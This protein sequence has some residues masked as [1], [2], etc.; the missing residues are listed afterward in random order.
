MDLKTYAVDATQ[1]IQ[2]NHEKVIL[3]VYA[4]NVEI[5]E[6]KIRIYQQ[7][8]QIR[9]NYSLLPLPFDIYIQ[10]HSDDNLIKPLK[11]IS[12]SLSEEDYLI[13]FSPNKVQFPL[14]VD[15]PCLQKIHQT[16]READEI[17]PFLYQPVPRS[18]RPYLWRDDGSCCYVI[19]NAQTNWNFPRC[20]ESENLKSANLFKGEKGEHQKE[21]APYLVALPPESELTQ[22]LFSP[23]KE[24]KNGYYSLQHWLSNFGFFFRSSAPFDKL[25]D[26]FRHFVYMP[27]YNERLLYFRF[28]DGK[29]ISQYLERLT[30]YP[31]KLNTFFGGDLIQGILVPD[32]DKFIYF[33]PVVDLTEYK[34]AK[35]QFDKFEMDAY[36][37][38]FNQNLFETVTNDII[39]S[40]SDLL[41]HYSKNE[42]AEI[43]LYNHK[44]SEKYRCIQSNTIIFFTLIALSYG[45]TIEQLDPEKVINQLLTVDYLTEKE[46]I[47]YINQR[48]TVLEKTQ[49]ITNLQE[50]TNDEFSRSL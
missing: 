13:V 23:H 9:L 38:N 11:T 34:T 32:N 15:F 42:I 17:T 39:E 49:Q 24:E 27:T 19:I 7:I 28:Y 37:D 50:N 22:A 14:K 3:L 20:F 47:Y 48:I 5:A 26:H 4:P 45:K 41:E 46:K 43:V 35:K 21:S 25:V 30:Y 36:R 33:E 10:R 40:N 18:V 29:V 12:Q 8:H 6:N 44:V 1:I 31:E 16:L 2:N